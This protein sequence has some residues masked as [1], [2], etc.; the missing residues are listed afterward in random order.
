MTLSLS[1]RRESE[2]LLRDYLF[3]SADDVVAG[4]K[5]GTIELNGET[6]ILEWLEDAEEIA[7]L[8]EKYFS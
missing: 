2:P 1:S 5:A 8:R 4:L 3:L 6:C 7:D